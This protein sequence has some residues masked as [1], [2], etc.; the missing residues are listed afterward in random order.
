MRL[1]FTINVRNKFSPPFPIGYY[2]NGIAPVLVVTTSRKL[3]QNPLE[4]TL[5]LIKSV[6]ANVTE[7]Y[8]RSLLD[9]FEIKGRPFLTKVHS[10]SVS[11]IRRL[12]FANIDFGRGKPTYGGTFKLFQEP[13]FEPTSLYI[14]LKNSQGEDGIMVPMCLPTS[15]MER[16]VKELYTILGDHVRRAQSN[17]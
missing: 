8:F 17:F 13:D 7:E 10:Y 16:F 4:Y 6:K 14:S 5:E 12:G 2:G 9:L 1:L 11:D 3:C 15:R